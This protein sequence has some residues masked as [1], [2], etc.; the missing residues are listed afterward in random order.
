M[1]EAILEMTE[2]R[3]TGSVHICGCD[4]VLTDLD[5]GPDWSC[6]AAVEHTY[7]DAKVLLAA[8]TE[9]ESW[10]TQW[11]VDEAD[12]GAGRQPSTSMKTAAQIVQEAIDAVASTARE[13]GEA[14]A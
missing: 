5:A 12:Q 14:G 10:Q 13:R 3:N 4:P 8:A 2:C 11:I 9:I 1:S 6:K 7:V